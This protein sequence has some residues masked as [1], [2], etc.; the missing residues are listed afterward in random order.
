MLKKKTFNCYRNNI[1]NGKD[2]SYM[3]KCK[4]NSKTDPLCPI[5][6]LKDIVGECGD[7]F[8]KVAFKVSC[9]VNLLRGIF[10]SFRL[11]LFK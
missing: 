7:D 3:K 4:Y 10:V 9:N 2:G 11:F 1:I 6:K 5:F 8:S